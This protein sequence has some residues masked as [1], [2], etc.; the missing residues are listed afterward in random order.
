M[1]QPPQHRFLTGAPRGIGRA[2]KPTQSGH[3]LLVLCQQDGQE[4]VST[5]SLVPPPDPDRLWVAISTI[6]AGSRGAARWLRGSPSTPT[7]ID[8]R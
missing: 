3:V 4:P 7:S 5:P 8:G 2:G 1:P 6:S